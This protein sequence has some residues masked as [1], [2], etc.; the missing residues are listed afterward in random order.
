MKIILLDDHKIFDQSLK[1]LLEEEETIEVCDYISNIDDFLEKIDK[2]DYDIL[3]IDIN[4][5]EEITGLDLIRNILS[6][7]PKEKIIVLTSYDLANYKDI[8][9]GL[10][11][12]DF[13]NKSIE[14]DELIRK[15]KNVH[16]GKAKESTKSIK[17]PLKNRELDVL[18]ELIKGSRKKDI[19]Q[20][21]YISERTLYN[22]IAN[23]YDKLGAKNIVEAYNKAMELGYI[24]PFM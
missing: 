16:Q 20:K 21:L 23:I 22:H 24:Y 6:Q 18:E 4:L 14:R 5:K 17:D 1:I 12:K 15:I 9:F 7:N 8:A 10:G 11:V 3:L 13:I 19:A 2:Y